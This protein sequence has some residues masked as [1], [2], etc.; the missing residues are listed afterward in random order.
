MHLHIS[1]KYRRNTPH[2]RRE[3]GRLQ[4]QL[5]VVGAHMVRRRRN[6][7][8][9]NLETRFRI[10]QCARDFQSDPQRFFWLVHALHAHSLLPEAGVLVSWKN[11]PEQE[12]I[13]HQGCWLTDA[14]EFYDF[15]V[16]VPWRNETPPVVE[17]WREVTSTTLISAHQPGTGKSFGWLALDV[18]WEIRD[19]PD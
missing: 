12:G 8:E 11:I 18:L 5:E 17:Y 16:I 13:I 3:A 9:Q 6:I 7:Q 14:A 1:A 15:S 10:L 4:G 19:T 2:P